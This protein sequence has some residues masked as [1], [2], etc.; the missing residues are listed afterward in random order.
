[1]IYKENG[2]ILKIDSKIDLKNQFNNGIKN[3]YDSN[4]SWVK[5]CQVNHHNEFYLHNWLNKNMTFKVSTK[6]LSWNDTCIWIE[7]IM[8][9]SKSKIK[10]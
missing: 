2:L 5:K 6:I 8:R 1:M 4:E 3:F 10:I 9:C 7:K